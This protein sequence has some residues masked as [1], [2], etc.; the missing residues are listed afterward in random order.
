MQCRKSLTCNNKTIINYQPLDNNQVN[1]SICYTRT[2][3]HLYFSISIRNTYNEK[4]KRKRTNTS[5]YLSRY[6]NNNLRF[7]YKQNQ[8]RR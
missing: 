8:T 6:L 2:N 1:T 3:T 5:T 7:H 4:V